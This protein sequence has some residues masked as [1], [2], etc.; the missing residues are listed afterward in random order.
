[1][2][3][4]TVSRRCWERSKSAAA[5]GRRGPVVTGLAVGTSL[6]LLLTALG[7]AAGVPS[8][9]KLG[10][11]WDQQWWWVLLPEGVQP[12][13]FG[14][15]RGAAYGALAGWAAAKQGSIR[16]DSPLAVRLAAPGTVAAMVALVVTCWD[17]FAGLDFQ[18]M[19]AALGAAVGRLTSLTWRGGCGG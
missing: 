15:V 9:W 8:L 16:R 12:W 11:L 14:A 7:V 10:F 17:T 2:P 3:L 4:W 19:F 5:L 18:V 1:M 6:H 13:A